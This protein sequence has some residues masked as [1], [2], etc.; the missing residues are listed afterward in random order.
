MPVALDLK[1]ADDKTLPSQE[2][3]CRLLVGEKSSWHS[4]RSGHLRL[5]RALWALSI[6]NGVL[7]PFSLY[8]LWSQLLKSGQREPETA[9]CKCHFLLQGPL[10]NLLPAPVIDAVPVAR[11]KFNETFGFEN[12]FQSKFVGNSSAADTEWE[13]YT[14]HRRSHSVRG[15]PRI[16]TLT[17]CSLA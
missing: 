15:I 11:V 1:D 9:W 6:V 17:C 10:V 8:I 14:M 3:W 7:L 13:R 4:N 5:R 2:E 16:C 12:L